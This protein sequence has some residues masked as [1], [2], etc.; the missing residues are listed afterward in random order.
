MFHYY[1]V[2]LNS[3]PFHFLIFKSRNDRLIIIITISL[4]KCRLLNESRL[5]I[6]YWKNHSWQRC[7][8]SQ[9]LL[10]ECLF[11]LFLQSTMSVC[12][13]SQMFLSI[14]VTGEIVWLNSYGTLAPIIPFHSLHKE[15][16]SL[17]MVRDWR[18]GIAIIWCICLW[19]VSVAARDK[20]NM[21]GERTW[22]HG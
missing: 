20:G 13:L 9:H 15:H 12:Q 16:K 21:A 4:A 11:H 22:K 7:Q 5:F 17:F 1:I 14:C 18:V 10:A 6:G 3:N 8:L 2:V 19:H